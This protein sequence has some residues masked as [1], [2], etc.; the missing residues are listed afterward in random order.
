M[1]LTQHLAAAS[2]LVFAFLSGG[3]DRSPAGDAG[4]RDNGAR[5]YALEPEDAPVQGD[6]AR[7]SGERASSGEAE[8]THAD[9]GRPVEPQP[10]GARGT[11]GGE[12]PA[13]TR[14]I[15]FSGL[16]APVPLSW[17]PEQPG[18]SMRAVQL[19]VAGVDGAGEA[20]LVV[21][22]GIG[23]SNESNISRWVGQ[24]QGEGGQ[25]VTPRVDEITVGDLRITTATLSG[26]FS[27]GMGVGEGGPGIMMVQSIV[28]KPGGEKVFI[29]LLG[30]IATVEAARPAFE[31]LLQGIR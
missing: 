9:A 13:G 7:A 6:V 4:I 21:F 1:S 28:E 8:R 20:R 25:P 5:V 22:V 17:E 27:G 11:P 2:F 3:C 12:D 19:R 10:P 23:G 15:S 14:R 30:P 18:S 16:S 24:F 31:A 26:T 29:R